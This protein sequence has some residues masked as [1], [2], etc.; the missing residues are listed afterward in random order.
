V[1]ISERYTTSSGKNYRIKLTYNEK[2]ADQ[3][4]AGAFVRDIEVFDD[5]T[6]EPISV[7]VTAARFSTFESYTSF[8]SFCAINYQGVRTAAIE[9]LRAKVLTRVE[10]SLERL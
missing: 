10:D 1:D 9:G 4:P 8:G 2:I 3:E 6:N 5:G 7:P